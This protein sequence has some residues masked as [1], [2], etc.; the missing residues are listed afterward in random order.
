MKQVL[1]ENPVINSR[2]VKIV[3]EVANSKNIGYNALIIAQR[4]RKV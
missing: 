1:I 2:Y 4:I 3:F